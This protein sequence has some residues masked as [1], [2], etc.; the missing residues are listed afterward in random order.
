[1]VIMS[2]INC[3]QDSARLPVSC[4]KTLDL[5]KLVHSIEVVNGQGSTEKRRVVARVVG[6][7][8]RA[9]RRGVSFEYEGGSGVRTT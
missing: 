6:L 5:C 4:S 9:R 1:M 8:R 3:K 7:W 2:D